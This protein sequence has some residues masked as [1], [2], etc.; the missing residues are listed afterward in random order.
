MSWVIG[1]LPSRPKGYFFFGPC[2]VTVMM[3]VH[4]EEGQSQLW[5]REK[6]ALLSSSAAHE[7][8][9]GCRVRLPRNGG[10]GGGFTATLAPPSMERNQL[11]S[12][13]LVFFA[14]LGT[15]LLHRGRRA[16]SQGLG[17]WDEQSDARTGSSGRRPVRAK[18]QK[19][20]ADSGS[21]GGHDFDG[22]MGGLGEGVKP[23]LRKSY[24]PG[25]R[26]ARRDDDDLRVIDC[27]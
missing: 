22:K 4:D 18:F 11:L 16:V 27:G 20:C 2:D 14:S 25:D 19:G 1:I 9:P 26:L 6:L 3:M 17:F 21:H 15:Y 5:F 24:V 8:Q 23:M 10:E 7:I 12:K 13:F